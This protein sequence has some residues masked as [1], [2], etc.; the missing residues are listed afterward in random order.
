MMG[1]WQFGQRFGLLP[2]ALC[3]AAWLVSGAI[4]ARA[5][6]DT[7]SSRPWLATVAVYAVALLVGVGGLVGFWVVADEFVFWRRRY[8][9]RWAGGTWLYE[10]RALGARRSFPFVPEILGEGYAAARKV[11][12]AAEADW[13][14]AMPQWAHGR[15]NEIMGRIAECFAGARVHFEER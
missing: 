12:I 11:R 15:R 8:R 2:S 14:T 6:A 5:L 3:W 7:L 4:A 10:E 13:D 9:V 1:P